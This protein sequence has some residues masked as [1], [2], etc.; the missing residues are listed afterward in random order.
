MKKQGLVPVWKRVWGGYVWERLLYRILF[1]VRHRVAD[2]VHGPVQGQI[3]DRVAEQVRYQMWALSA[4]RRSAI[5]SPPRKL[6]I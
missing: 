6:E 1:S 3:R 4:N 5:Y 2:Q